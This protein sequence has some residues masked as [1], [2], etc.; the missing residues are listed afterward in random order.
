MD[1]ETEIKG[2]TLEYFDDEHMYLVDGI[3]V[4]SITQLLKYRFKNKYASVDRATLKRASESGTAVHNAIE[5]YC[6]NGTESDLPEVRNFK[7]LQKAYNFE[8][9]DNEVPVI[10]FDGD[11]PISAGRLDLVI[12]QRFSP[13][14]VNNSWSEIGLGDI[15]RTATLDK[16]YLAYQLN[17]YRIAYQQNYDTEITFLKGLHLREDKRKYVDIPINEKM[18]WEL[19]KEYMVSKRK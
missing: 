12:E 6:R 14:S 13:V 15:K 18:A 17:L 16:E 4:P 8:V 9:F 19:V 2:H 7:F 5:E 1:F 11:T 3:I 10:L